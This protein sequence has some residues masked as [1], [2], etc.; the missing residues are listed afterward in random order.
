MRAHSKFNFKINF[1]KF[2][3]SGNLF[4]S[5]HMYE[6]FSALSK[7]MIVAE[8]LRVLYFSL[9]YFMFYPTYRYFHDKIICSFASFKNPVALVKNKVYGL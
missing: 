9:S 4:I 3:N 5:W 7:I 8:N 1:S 2:S 6:A